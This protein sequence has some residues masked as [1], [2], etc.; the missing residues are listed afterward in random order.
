[1]TDYRGTWTETYPSSITRAWVEKRLRGFLRYCVDAGW[2]DRVPKL[3]AIKMD[4]PPTMPLTEVEYQA[5]LAAVP[6]G[7]P[8]GLGKRLRALFRF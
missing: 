1:M 8:N 7:F 4:E 5:L 6:L 2:L 3:T